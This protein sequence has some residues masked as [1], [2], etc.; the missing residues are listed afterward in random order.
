MCT[1][2]PHE[3]Q[4]PYSHSFICFA[5]RERGGKGIEYTLQ[6]NKHGWDMAKV[7]RLAG[8]TFSTD[9]FYFMTR[10]GEVLLV[11]SGPARDELTTAITCVYYTPPHLRNKCAHETISV[12]RALHSVHMEKR[13]I[14]AAKKERRAFSLESSASA[15]VAF[16]PNS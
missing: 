10:V 14:Y 11:P 5:A 16:Y 13:T 15:M 6:E 9:E 7:Y 3:V 8:T 2:A 12:L 4:R 1:I